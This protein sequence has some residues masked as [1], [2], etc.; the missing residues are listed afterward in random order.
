M[1]LKGDNMFTTPQDYFKAVQDTFAAFPKTPED[2]SAVLEKTRNVV[3][4]EAE[5]A[6]SVIA[7]YNKAASGDAS[8]NEITE[9]NKKAKELLVAARFATVMALP[10][11]VFVLP[12]LTKMADEYN[13][14]FVPAS[15]KKEFGI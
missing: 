15:V 4:I 7:T 2:V 14:D 6:K 3:T 1:A 12:I 13:V 10:G 9:A 5:N 11:A 8:M